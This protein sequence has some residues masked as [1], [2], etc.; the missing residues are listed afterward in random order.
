MF[1]ENTT[2]VLGA[3]ASM[4]YGY[5]SGYQLVTDIIQLVALGKAKPAITDRQFADELNAAGIHSDHAVEFVSAL[6]EAFPPSI[7][8]FLFHNPQF[9]NV[10]KLAIAQRIICHE[11]RHK[12]FARPGGDLFGKDGHDRWYHKLVDCIADPKTGDITKSLAI[13]T[14]NYD[15]SL[16]C[17]LHSSLKRR[18]RLSDEEA[19]QR[20]AVI[21]IVHVYGHVGLLPWHQKS[22]DT[23][24]MREYG[25]SGHPG[26]LRE[27]A[28]GIHTIGGSR[29]DEPARAREL[30]AASRHVFILG[31]G[32]QDDNCE[33]IGLK[34]SLVYSPMI[35]RCG[36]S[37]AMRNVKA[38]R[39]NLTWEDKDEE[40][41]DVS[42]F[43]DS[44]SSFL[45]AAGK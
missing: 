17:F 24:P 42:T 2:I 3:G 14:F 8:Y 36:L 40:L 13:A 33:L 43:L 41:W 28:K 37:I 1:T 39:Y 19:A 20:L 4:P 44:S 7:D 29:T 35:T 32:F 16:P 10:G 25:H 12:L 38:Q 18:F 6:Y 27:A 23:D 26:E 11:N 34:S 15:R 45:A 31:F 21:P 22:S 30:I 9:I 5:P